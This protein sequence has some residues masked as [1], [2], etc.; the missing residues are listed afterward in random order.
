MTITP[1]T[2]SRNF[3]AGGADAK[4][5]GDNWSMG[6]DMIECLGTFG[7][8]VGRPPDSADMVT[9]RNRRWYRSSA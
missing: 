4:S 6:W 5:V 2:T 9:S 7:T 1:N 3:L 8:T